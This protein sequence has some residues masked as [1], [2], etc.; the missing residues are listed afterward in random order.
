MSDAKV[1]KQLK[2]RSPKFRGREA[3]FKQLNSDF[4][5]HWEFVICHFV[6]FTPCPPCSSATS[7]S[8]S[9]IDLRI[10]NQE[11][12][13]TNGKNRT[14]RRN[15]VSVKPKTRLAINSGKK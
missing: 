10:K 8:S 9:A 2:I 11:I 1:R 3:A 4:F 14:P 5:R 12:S 15:Q 7:A 6:P 13:H